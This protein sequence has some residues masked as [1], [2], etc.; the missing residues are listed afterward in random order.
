VGDAVL[1][2]RSKRGEKMKST[3]GFLLAGITLFIFGIFSCKSIGVRNDKRQGDSAGG[4]L[5]SIGGI[6]QQDEKR[7]GIQYRLLCLGLSPVLGEVVEKDRIKFSNASLKDG[8]K[9]ALE[10]WADVD[11]LISEWFG[12]NDKGQRVAG[13]YYSSDLGEIVGQRLDLKLYRLYSSPPKDPFWA[14]IL[15]KLPEPPADGTSL[16]LSLVCG[17]R[18][19]PAQGADRINST[20]LQWMFTV[21]DLSVEKMVSSEACQEVQIRQDKELRWHQFFAK[22]HFDFSKATLRETLDLGGVELL[23]YA[24]LDLWADAKLS[25]VQCVQRDATSDHCTE[26]QLPQNVGRWY[27]VLDDGTANSQKIAVTLGQALSEPGRSIKVSDI[28]QAITNQDPEWRFYDPSV[29]AQWLEKPVVL[30]EFVNASKLSFQEIGAF[31]PGRFLGAAFYGL[32]NVGYDQQVELLA[33]RAKWRWLARLWSDATPPVA[34][35]V[36]GEDFFEGLLDSNGKLL[37][38][39]EWADKAEKFPAYGVLARTSSLAFERFGCKLNSA[40]F[41]FEFSG[42]DDNR[43]QQ[44][45]VV[46]ALEACRLAPVDPE[47]FRLKA[48]GVRL[49]VWAWKTYNY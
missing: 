7:L 25:E 6:E 14:K 47:S 8:V 3:A 30:S 43:W 17:S 33:V 26:V 49:F 27:V 37:D 21:K 40:E 11:P 2:Y 42:Y 48:A 36:G 34:M 31:N 1:A 35:I 29:A 38:V 41:L 24:S 39:N 9:C 22:D 28:Q 19:Y 18:N 20:G 32:N 5:A 10:V 44:P 4:I 23:A 46:S 13:L 16:R 15:V 45:G 12:V